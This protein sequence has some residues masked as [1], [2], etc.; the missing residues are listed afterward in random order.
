MAKCFL[1]LE[2]GTIMEGTGFGSMENTYGEV[3][4]CTGMTGYQEGLTDPS[5][6]GQ[7]LTMSYPL[8]GNYGVR[9]EDD[10]SDCVQVRGFVVRELCEHP[11]DVYGGKDLNSYLVENGIPGIAGV[12]TR[13][14]IIKI[15]TAGTMKGAIVYEG[16]PATHLE[17][18]RA[19][20]Y[21]S[22]TGLVP[23]ASTPQVLHYPKEGAK[24]V[25]ILDC[26]TKRSIVEELRRRFEVYQLP[27]DTG[28][29]FFRDHHVDGIF[30]SN[31]PGNPAHVTLKETV[32]ETVRRLRDDYPIMGICMGNQLLCQVFGGTTFKMKFGHRGANQPVRYQDRVFVTSQNH[33]YAI[34][35]ESLQGSGMEVDQVNVN[36][37]TVEGIRHS[38][39][40]IFSVQYHPEARP[41]PLDTGFLFDDFARMMEGGS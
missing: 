3:V 30:L 31:G 26:G 20:P 13:S 37:G 10:E 38:E 15:R 11:T 8:V 2:D 41:G 1:L 36:D 34:D 17:K 14:L 35:P 28:V 40:P 33:G 4:F 16:D 27:Y 22:E 39:L 29:D 25:A 12:D 21:P 5:F 9:T 32:I 19:M 6:R 7:I 23:L 18:I 24:K